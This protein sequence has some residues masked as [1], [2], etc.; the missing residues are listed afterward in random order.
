[1]TLTLEMLK[2]AAEKMLEEANKPPEPPINII[3]PAAYDMAL[4]I[5]EIDP[6]FINHGPGEW[7]IW[8]KAQELGLK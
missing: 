8:A 7:Y 1:M 6:K 2:A 4:R 3:S 5:L